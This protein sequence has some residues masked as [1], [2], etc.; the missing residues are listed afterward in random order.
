[1]KLVVM[2]L[3]VLQYL[4][5][6]HEAVAIE[7]ERLDGPDGILPIGTGRSNPGRQPVKAAPGPGVC[8]NA[9]LV[10]ADTGRRS[11][12]DEQHVI[13]PIAREVN[14]SNAESVIGHLGTWR[15]C[16]RAV[17]QLGES[18]SARELRLHAGARI[19][20]I[21]QAVPVHIREMEVPAVRVL[22]L[23]KKREAH[24]VE[25]W[26]QTQFIEEQCAVAARTHEKQLGPRAVCHRANLIVE[27][28]GVAGIP[29]WGHPVGALL[30]WPERSVVESIPPSET[31]AW[32]ALRPVFNDG[33]YIVG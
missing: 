2:S 20:G 17:Q 16:T 6:V 11:G 1:M 3:P 15:V 19:D 26:E 28:D 21:V 31:E 32:D 14:N 12:M 25:A 7:V 13:N 8:L 5:N 33:A 4:R 23:Q 18:E 27:R 30:E 24:G 10:V 29:H 9:L 22:R